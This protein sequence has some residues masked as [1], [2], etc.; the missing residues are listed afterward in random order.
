[1]SAKTKRQQLGELIEF[2]RLE[3]NM[4]KHA[5]ADK[6]RAT[7]KDV[8][9]WGRGDLVPTTQEWQRMR[10]VFPVINAG[11]R[12]RELFEGAAAEQLAIETA[13]QTAK[14]TPQEKAGDMDAAIRLL[15]DAVP[16]LCSLSIEVDEDGVASVSFRTRQV[17]IVEDAGTM[18][19]RR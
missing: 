16:G 13:R 19:V 1:M 6:T 10:L 15:L 17:R 5:L 8:D 12:Y 14:E 3:L 2:H 11:N 4:S 7:T 18:Q 9:R